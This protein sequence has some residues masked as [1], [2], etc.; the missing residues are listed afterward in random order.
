MK[1]LLCTVTLYLQ[2]TV[3]QA[4][5]YSHIPAVYFYFYQHYFTWRSDRGGLGLRVGLPIVLQYVGHL[6]FLN[7]LFL[8]CLLHTASLSLID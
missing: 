7:V 4:H 3:A 1:Y 5:Q 6:I 2:C 8:S